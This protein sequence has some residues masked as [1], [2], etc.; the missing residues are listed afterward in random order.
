[1]LSSKVCSSVT[2]RILVLCFLLHSAPALAEGGRPVKLFLLGG[3]SNMEGCGESSELPDAF[4][5]HPDNVR[6]WDNKNSLWAPLGQ[7]S[8]AIARNELFGPEV[9]FAHRL[10]KVWPDHTIA[11]V[12]T[13]GGG[14]KLH[15]QWIPGKGM[16][17]WFISNQT[18]AVQ[19]LEQSNTNYEIA[20]MLW[21]QGESD[22]ETTEMANA[23]E[24][25]LK[26]LIKHVRE[27]TKQAKLPFVMG[28]ISSSLLKKT[29][30]VFDHARIVQKAQEAVA[31][32]DDHTF[33]I[34]TDALSTLKD[35]T[36]FDTSAQLKLGDEMAIIMIKELR[37]TANTSKTKGRE[38]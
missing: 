12:K 13:A 36:H 34:N 17:Q 27:Q 29:P 15:T 1:M 21:M 20:G 7:D 37:K 9:A 35:N 32:K 38:Q 31:T 25:N 8:T 23:Y 10:S 33:I 30:W 3:Q 26:A 6:I 16:Y 19:D 14:T 18:K 4:K 28:R 5:K 24:E 2:L 11:L 22:S